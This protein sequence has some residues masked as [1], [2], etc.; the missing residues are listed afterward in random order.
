LTKL[1]STFFLILASISMGASAKDLICVHHG[2]EPYWINKVSIHLDTKTV[3]VDE[4]PYQARVSVIHGKVAYADEKAING[5]PAV[6]FATP[7]TLDT[8][9]LNLFKLFR[10]ANG[11]RLIDTGVLYVNGELTLKALGHSEPFDCSDSWP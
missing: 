1:P 10:S 3:D 4:G 6:A 7:Q 2:A 8:N 5:Y 9:S 11:W